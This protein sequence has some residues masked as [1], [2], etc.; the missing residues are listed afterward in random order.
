[1][2]PPLYPLATPT[3][4]D[5]NQPDFSFSFLFLT[6]SFPWSWK[7][8][9]KDKRKEM[10]EELNTE[11]CNLANQHEELSDMKKF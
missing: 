11:T 1:M 9:R 5:L 4:Q 10:T 8:E 3:P 2:T 7:F 6:F